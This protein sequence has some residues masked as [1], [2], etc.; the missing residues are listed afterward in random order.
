VEF[1]EAWWP[2]WSKASKPFGVQVFIHQDAPSKSVDFSRFR[3]LPISHTAQDDIARELGEAAWIIPMGSGACRSFP[4]Y[5]AWKAGCEYI[6]TLD[7]DCFP[8]AGDGERFLESHLSAFVRDRWFRTILSDHPRGVP[9]ERT[10]TLPVRLNHG[11]WAEIPDLDAPTTLIRLREPRPLIRP[12][13]S[14][15]IPPGMAFPLCGMN[16]C[17]HR[18][19]VPACYNLL[20]GM[21]AFGID[22]FDDIWS[23]LL[24]KR[25]LDYQGWYA[26]S[27]E[28]VVRHLKASNPFENLRRE[29]L[30]IA[31]HERFWDF[32]LDAPLE[33]GLNVPSIFRA[34][35]ERVRDFPRYFPDLPC[36][37]GYFER[38]G[39]AMS[40]WCSLFG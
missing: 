35:A 28:P 18:A 33:P 30:G 12:R 2:L 22:R 17:Y 10:G 39:D 6:L 5:L 3:G 31:L 24:I 37:A 27:G 32:I 4:I 26:T 8:D 13:G 7:D 16:V 34:L 1:L 20:M 23:G 11:L 21:P 19:L 36:P 40:V 9:Y 29:A 38:T 25:V 15:V 14:E